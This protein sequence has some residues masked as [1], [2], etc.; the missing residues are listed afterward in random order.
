MVIWIA[1]YPRSGSNYF[2]LLLW[3]FY[4]YFPYSLYLQEE[5][6][7]R[8]NEIINRW[9]TL[10]GI[11]QLQP[12]NMATMHNVSETYFVKT[13]ELPQDDLP[14][15]YLVRDGRDVLVSYAHFILTFETPKAD[16]EST[17]RHVTMDSGYFGGWGEHL[18]TW[19][20]RQAPT[21]IV[22]F[23]EFVRSPNPLNIVNQALNRVGCQHPEAPMIN[24]LPTFE[25]L[26]QI[27]PELFRRGR[28]GDWQTEMPTTVQK[29]FW[30]KHGDAMQQMGY[31][32]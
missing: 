21:A 27:L 16:F 13:H 20:Q 30:Q 24:S 15:I 11:K 8:D 5:F 4:R 25:E 29:L 9:K 12:I 28:I 31:I 17:L 19:T 26:H 2:Q 10:L 18:L 3:H 14:T 22:K 6:L 7:K 23:E 1:S 32:E